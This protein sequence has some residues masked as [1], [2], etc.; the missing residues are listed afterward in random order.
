MEISYNTK[1]AL[2]LMSCN[3]GFEITKELNNYL[4][5]NVFPQDIDASGSLVGQIKNHENSAQLIF[6]HD[7][8]DVGEE[9]A[10]YLIRLANQYM[11]YVESDAV[12]DRKGEEVSRSV[13]NNEK[14]YNPKM[15]SMWV[16]R[17]YAGDY[18]PEHDHPSDADIGLSCI[19]YLT[20]PMG[21]SSGDGSLGSTS[22]TGASGVVDGYT[23]FSWGTTSTTDMKKLKPSTEQYVKPEIG[24]LL[25]FPSWLNHSVLPFTGEG[26]RRSLSAN[27]N[28]FPSGE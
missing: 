21:I 24:Q 25:M 15:K 18:N 20:I 27:I 3:F 2:T 12:T 6:P 26:E 1:T 11:D 10:G 17:S 5:E 22:L 9:L 13:T 19:M 23:R 7:D 8:N 28:M 16:N 14:K 4:E